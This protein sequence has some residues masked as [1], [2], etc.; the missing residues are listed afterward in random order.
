MGVCS[1]KIKK[2]YIN[3]I[4][5]NESYLWTILALIFYIS[6]MFCLLFFLD[7]I[8]LYFVKISEFPIIFLFPKMGILILQMSSLPNVKCTNNKKI[9]KNNFYIIFI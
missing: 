2:F 8:L 5:S 1:T 4:P 9:K 7:R 6:I 3:F